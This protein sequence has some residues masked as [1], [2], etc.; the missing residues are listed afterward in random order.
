[1]SKLSKNVSNL[2]AHDMKN[3]SIK[4][5]KTL[6]S[7]GYAE[8]SMYE[9]DAQFYEDQNLTMVR[10]PLEGV[11]NSVPEEITPTS[12]A[13]FSL[14]FSGEPLLRFEEII[15]YILQQQCRLE[16]EL[17]AAEGE[18]AYALGQN[19]VAL[20][21][22]KTLAH[23]NKGLDAFLE[24]GVD[25]I[26]ERLYDHLLENPSTISVKR[27]FLI[28]SKDPE[29]LRGAMESVPEIPRALIVADD[30]RSAAEIN[31][32]LTLLE[33]RGVMIKQSTFTDELNNIE[34]DED[35]FMMLY[36]MNDDG[37]VEQL[38]VVGVD[39]IIIQNKDEIAHIHWL[40]VVA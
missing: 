10:R 31:A 5:F 32:L 8:F 24:I 38:L 2:I 3:D 35:R 21:R 40:P 26:L 33:C 16:I 36:Q 20:L 18:D 11:P 39:N 13:W 23:F 14:Q 6:L 19:V 37:N 30:S 17:S 34:F 29:I 4:T 1:M 25:S 28:S 7:D 15:D 12:G 22:T 9:C 27:Q